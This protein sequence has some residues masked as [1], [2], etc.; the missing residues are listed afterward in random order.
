M[1]LKI[2]LFVRSNF[3]INSNQQQM[4]GVSDRDRRPPKGQRR[5]QNRDQGP[6]QGP[7]RQQWG[8]LDRDKGPQE[9]DYLKEPERR[10]SLPSSAD[11][12]TK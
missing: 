6:Q 1:P 11:Y 3:L 10:Y 9:A 12:T 8:V 7:W 2:F 4:T 5:R